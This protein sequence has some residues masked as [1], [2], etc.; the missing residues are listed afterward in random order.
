MALQFVPGNSGAGKSF[1]LYQKILQEAGTH[2]ERKYLVIVPE[3][4]TMQ[5]QK[6]LVALS[7]R[8]GIMNVDI[9]S[10]DRLA[11]RVFAEV[12]GDQTPVLEDVG[13][14]L[15]LERVVQEQ[16]KKLG[17]LG[18]SLEKL[19]TVSEMKS[20]LSELM[21]YDIHP[22]ELDDRRRAAPGGGAAARP[23]YRGGLCQAAGHRRGSG[24]SYLQL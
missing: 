10:F 15:V 13:K 8:H 20:L 9:L 3:Q 22:E 5:T 1:Q 21:Q 7:P 14:I 6:E 4:F 2:P 24:R 17:V 11:H 19:G 12:G 23:L 18:S 16:K